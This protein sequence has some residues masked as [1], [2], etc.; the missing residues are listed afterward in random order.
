MVAVLVP[1]LFSNFDRFYFEIKNLILRKSAS[2]YAELLLYLIRNLKK[3]ATVE[4]LSNSD[5]N[6]SLEQIA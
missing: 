2:Q 6:Y 1:Y 5:E 4:V 3:S